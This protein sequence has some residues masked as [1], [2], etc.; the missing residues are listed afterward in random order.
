MSAAIH[1][2]LEQWHTYIQG[3]AGSNVAA[4]EHLI[5][6]DCI[7]YSPVVFTPQR[8]GEITRIYLSAAAGTLGGSEEVPFIYTKEIVSENQAMLEFETS[9]DGKTVNG[10][11]IITCNDDA[12]ITEFKVMVRPLQ[13]VTAVHQAMMRMLESMQIQ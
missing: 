5:H 7:F 10:V 6:D 2:C 11:D 9:V 12:Q 13:A 8:G 1:K 3:S 4:L